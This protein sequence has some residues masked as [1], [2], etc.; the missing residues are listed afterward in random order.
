MIISND[1]S[2]ALV[3]SKATE[4]ESWIKQYDLKTYTITFE[5]IIGGDI[6]HDFVKCKEVEQNNV[7]D[8]YAVVYCNNGN[9]KLR[10]FGKTQR[11]IEQI[12]ENE[13]EINNLLGINDHTMPHEE[14]NDPFINCCFVNDS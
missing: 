9:F 1:S 2:K 13:V 10:T 4:Y 11:T 12:Q 5:E 6:D 14:L 3:I 7:G 8:K